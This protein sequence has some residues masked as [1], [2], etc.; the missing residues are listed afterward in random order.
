[1]GSAC[2][3]QSYLQ[4]TAEGIQR[5]RL[6]EENTAE[7]IQRDTTGEQGPVDGDRATHAPVDPYDGLVVQDAATQ[8]RQTRA[9]PARAARQDPQSA[10]KRLVLGIRHLKFKRRAWYWTGAWLHAVK[11][12]GRGEDHFLLR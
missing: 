3:R 7:G 11:N 6:Q 8:T 12:R 10:W 4:N 5:N 9:R 2:R 1:M